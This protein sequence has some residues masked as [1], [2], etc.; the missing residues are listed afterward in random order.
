MG[1]RAKKPVR[2]VLSHPTDPSLALVQLTRGFFA[3]IDVIDAA[4]VGRFN[5]R[6]QRSKNT[7][8][9]YRS[10]TITGKRAAIGLHRDIADRAGLPLDVEIDHRNLNGLDCRRMNLRRATKA[11]NQ[12]NRQPITASGFKHVTQTRNGRWQVQIKHGGKNLYLG[13]FVDKAD[14]IEVS[15]AAMAKFHGEFARLN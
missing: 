15:R 3:T 6:A 7:V 13:R 1:D 2:L 5:W 4:F 11:Q 8:Y 14:A 12:M 9:A 10:E